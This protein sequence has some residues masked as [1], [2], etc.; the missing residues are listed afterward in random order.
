MLRFFFRPAIVIAVK[1][2]MKAPAAASAK[3]ANNI[4]GQISSEAPMQVSSIF[5]YFTSL[6]KE[7]KRD[8]G[9]PPLAP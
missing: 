1:R 6:E 7:P 4:S 8:G 9:P 3:P 5:P 2:A